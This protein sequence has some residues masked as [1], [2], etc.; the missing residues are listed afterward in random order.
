MNFPLSTNF[1]V[2]FPCLFLPNKYK[3]YCQF[4][5]QVLVLWRVNVRPGSGHA[6]SFFFLYLLKNILLANHVAHINDSFLPHNIT[7]WQKRRCQFC[8]LWIAQSNQIAIRSPLN[9]PDYYRMLKEHITQVL[10]TKTSMGQPRTKGSDKKS[11]ATSV[12]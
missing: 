8:F 12:W 11:V 5:N 10:Q 7:I 1:P 2:P 9:K 4:E 6:M 3:I